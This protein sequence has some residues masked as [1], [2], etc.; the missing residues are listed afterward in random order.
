MDAGA[1]GSSG[2]EWL[3]EAPPS[4]WRC[5]CESICIYLLQKATYYVRSYIHDTCMY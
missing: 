2:A 5:L 3:H 1:E 4:V